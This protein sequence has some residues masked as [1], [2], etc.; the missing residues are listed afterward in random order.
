M[1][2]KI[3]KPCEPID[4]LNSKRSTFDSLLQPNNNAPL[5]GVRSHRDVGRAK[6]D[7]RWERWLGIAA[8]VALGLALGTFF[9]IEEWGRSTGEALA[10]SVVMIVLIVAVLRYGSQR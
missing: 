2:T 8:S 5:A 6:R 7:R 10:V 1:D 9:G 4:I 3:G